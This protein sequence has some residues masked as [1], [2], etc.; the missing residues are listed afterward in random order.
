MSLTILPRHSNLYN[1]NRLRNFRQNDLGILQLV[2]E[3]RLSSI[4]Q[5]K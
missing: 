4:K 2:F 3:K 5:S 1:I